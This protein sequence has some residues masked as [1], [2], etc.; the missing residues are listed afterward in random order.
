MEELAKRLAKECREIVQ[1]VLYE[2]E[3]GDAERE[4]YAV[5]LAGLKDV[6][7]RNQELRG[8]ASSE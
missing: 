4:F 1:D 3:R 8:S 6:L 5:I 2:W 7:S